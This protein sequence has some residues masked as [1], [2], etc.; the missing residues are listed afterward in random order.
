[1]ERN[2]GERGGIRGGYLRIKMR[3]TC[4]FAFAGLA[5]INQGR[6]HQ[7]LDSGSLDGVSGCSGVVLLVRVYF[8][9]IRHILPLLNLNIRR[10]GGPEICDAED[11]VCALKGFFK[12]GFV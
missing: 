3:H 4:E 8:C 12:R 7:V 10:H 9:T 2:E 5:H 11:A 1:M 6:K